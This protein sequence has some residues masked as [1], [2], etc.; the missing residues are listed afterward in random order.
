MDYYKTVEAF[1][2]NYNQLKISI[3]NIKKEIEE[4]HKAE[5]IG[6]PSMGQGEKTG[7]TYK[8]HSETESEGVNIADK[9]ELLQQ[10][11]DI[12]QSKISRLDNAINALNDMEQKIIKMH[13]IEGKQWWQ[14]AYEVKYAESW[15]R[16]IRKRAV[17]KIAV[18]LF[19]D[20]VLER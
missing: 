13:Y 10:R 8:F 7:R 12:I 16:E 18:G 6:L 14:I 20:K 5:N 19:G 15:C 17:N 1:L 9:T 2:Y 3:D 11:I 4:L